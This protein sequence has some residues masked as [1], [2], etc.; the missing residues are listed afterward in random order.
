MG[1]LRQGSRS[2]WRPALRPPYPNVC[3]S[4]GEK[5]G[6]F[7][8]HHWWYSAGPARDEYQR[9]EPEIIAQLNI[10]FTDTIPPILHIQ[11]YMIGRSTDTAR[12]TIMFFGQDKDARKKAKKTVDN[13]D[14][15]CR[16]PGFRTGHQSEDPGRGNLISPASGDSTSDKSVTQSSLPEPSASQQHTKIDQRASVSNDRGFQFIVGGSLRELKSKKNMT[17]VR[18]RAMREYLLNN[19]KDLTKPKRGDQTAS[20]QVASEDLRLGGTSLHGV[21]FDASQPIGRVGMPIFVKQSVGPPRKATA[22]V[23]FEGRKCW[24]LSVSHVFSDHTLATGHTTAEVDS[25]FDLGSGSETEDSNIT[26]D[27]TSR[28]SISSPESLSRE[29]SGSSSS[30]FAIS[31]IWDQPTFDAHVPLE[32]STEHDSGKIQ[33]HNMQLE[34]VQ[35]PGGSTKRS[36]A[37]DW[38][39]IEITN[40]EFVRALSDVKLI[41]QTLAG[42]IE[43]VSATP[44]STVVIWTS[45]G[46]VTG[47]LMD[48]TVCM[49]LPHSATFERLQ[50]IKLN[51][52]LHWGDCGSMVSFAGST[53][54]HGFVVASSSDRS[55]AYITSASRVLADSWTHW[56]VF[57]PIPANRALGHALRSTDNPT[58]LIRPLDP[59]RLDA[60]KEYPCPLFKS[61]GLGVDP[62]R[63]MFQN[64]YHRVSVEQ[65][66]ILCEYQI[67]AVERSY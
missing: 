47:Q 42:S 52:P 18:K 65:M 30:D 15:L 6:F 55:I 38:I 59:T 34:Q 3:N 9:V 60:Y 27:A 2:W 50:S 64:P 20:S 16:L 24:F 53:E 29:R 23:V 63:L 7:H 19:Y 14:L 26:S 40:P 37:L 10:L 28:A 1:D 22:N 54:P 61:F 13:S 48:E 39:L 11:L 5:A 62:F 58:P 21:Y 43:Q 12:P 31:S 67:F 33:D 57:A 46:R 66:K 25:D 51:I 41:A 36:F 35:G 17:A 49:R 56:D 32:N 8:D 45:H 4:L 44:S